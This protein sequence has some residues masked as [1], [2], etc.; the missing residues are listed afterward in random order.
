MADEKNRVGAFNVADALSEPAEF[1][2]ERAGPGF[3]VFITFD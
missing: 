2:C 1:V 3:A